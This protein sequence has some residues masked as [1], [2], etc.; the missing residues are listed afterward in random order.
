MQGLIIIKVQSEL[1]KQALLAYET[2]IYQAVEEVENAL[3]A[4]ARERE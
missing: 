3:Y 2:A 1:Q 4:M